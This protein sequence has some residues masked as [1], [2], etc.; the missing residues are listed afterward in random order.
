M[1][2]SA[3]RTEIERFYERAT[4]T[5]VRADFARCAVAA[6]RLLRG[7]RPAAPEESL[8]S[9]R[10]LAALAEHG[11]A[12]QPA[13]HLAYGALCEYAVA[14][15]GLDTGDLDRVE[16][17]LDAIDDTVRDPADLPLL[18]ARLKLFAEHFERFCEEATDA[19]RP[20]SDLRISAA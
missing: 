19:R 14:R 12:E 11:L 18:R 6:Q 4:A 8:P 20:R 9:A 10:A 3:L 7:A 1:I 17:A 13:A 5:V 15:M 16:S 2:A